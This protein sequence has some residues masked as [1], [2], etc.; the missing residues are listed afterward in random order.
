MTTSVSISLVDVFGEQPLT[1]NPLAV[2]RGAWNLSTEAM[3]TTARWLNFS[4]TTFIGPPTSPQA[5]YAVRIFTLERELPFAGHPTLGT[6][7]AWLVNGGKPKVADCIIQESAIGQVQLRRSAGRLAF[8][9]PPLLRGGPVE[10][11]TIRELIDVLGVERHEVID[12]NWGDNGPGWVMLLL[13]SAERVQAL[14]PKASHPTKVDVGVIGPWAPG[15]ETAFE[16]RAFF[17][18]HTGA[19]REDPVTGSLNAAVAMWMFGSGRARDRYVAS[20]GTC[21]GRR[22]RVYLSRDDHDQVWVA[23]N[24]VTLAEGPWSGVS[25][26]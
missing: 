7:H 14:K 22:G 12:A 16:L 20:Q 25:A 21:L 23:G 9:A 26:R 8:Q 18:D 6:C 10:E 4:E 5:D 24:T 17:S 19:I 15:N 1:G 11:A 3:Q 13:P 2:I